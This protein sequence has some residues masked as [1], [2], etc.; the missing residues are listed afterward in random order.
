MP[1][2]TAVTATA[3]AVGAAALT[4]LTG[5][6]SY[7]DRHSTA[8]STSSA[9]LGAAARHLPGE[10]VAITVRRDGAVV[11]LAALAVRRRRG[12][13][14]VEVLGGGLNDYAELFHDDVDAADVL[15][16][17]I[18]AWIRGH[19]RWSLALS[20][21]APEDPV[22]A[23]LR[24]RLPGAT[25]V[26]GPPMPRIDGPGT[27]YRLSRNRRRKP[28]TALNRL[29]SDGLAATSLEV[30]DPEGFERWLPAVIDVRRGRDHG[31][32]RRSHLDDPATR[33]FYEAFVRAAVAEGRARMHLLV[34][35]EEV[36]GFATTMTDGATLRLYDGRVAQDWL[37]YRGGIVCEMA[38]VQRA[39][40]DPGITTFDWLRG[41]TEAKFGN[42]EIHR[43]ELRAASHAWI[44]AVDA[45]EARARSRVKAMLPDA[46]VRRIAER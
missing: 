41:R 3:V 37:R 26:A 38:A 22:L 17:A 25:V 10:P 44:G 20:Q 33:A 8:F 21:L 16:E 15:A 9:W 40:A 46:A 24:A 45:W 31:S 34:V 18:A 43:C 29:A 42:A 30:D 35:G 1:A 28:H 36:L 14:R 27:T 6:A 32:G 39:V 5:L 4:E 19:R 2:R 7:V 12:V 23:G 13:T 11:G